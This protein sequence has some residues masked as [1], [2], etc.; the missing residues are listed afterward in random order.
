MEWPWWGQILL[1]SQSRPPDLTFLHVISEFGR[2]SFFEAGTSHLGRG[3][4]ALGWGV[5]LF[6]ARAFG[7]SKS[8]IVTGVCA[9]PPPR[10]PVE[11]I[12]GQIGMFGLWTNFGQGVTMAF[13]LRYMVGGPI[14]FGGRRGPK[15]DRLRRWGVKV[16]RWI[17][18]VV[19]FYLGAPAIHLAGVRK[20]GY[21]RQ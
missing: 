4:L 8:N 5:G 14:L 11:V 19:A 7:T 6:G 17:L 10:G 16:M 2:R 21:E 20:R 15:I 3:E 12:P 1:T 13:G 9:C 18:F